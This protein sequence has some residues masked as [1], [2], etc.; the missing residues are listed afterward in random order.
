MD[1]GSFS[2][3]K[4]YVE[5]CTDSYTQ[6]DVLTLIDVLHTNFNLNCSIVNINKVK[7]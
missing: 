5:L 1:D 6:N 4:G 2:K 7:K 3:H